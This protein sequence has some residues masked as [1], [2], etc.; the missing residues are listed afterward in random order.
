MWELVVYVPWF[1]RVPLNERIE[2][3]LEH[4]DVPWRFKPSEQ[5]HF[6]MN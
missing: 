2:P 4:E 6:K 1:A 3:N 5:D